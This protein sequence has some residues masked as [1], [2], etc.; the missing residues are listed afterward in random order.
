MREIKHPTLPII[1]RALSYPLGVI[2]NSRTRLFVAELER[3]AGDVTIATKGK[4]VKGRNEGEVQR[5]ENN[6]RL[7]GDAQGSKA[8]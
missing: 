8:D 6:G 5:L 7:G 2:S 3:K 4:R 1:V